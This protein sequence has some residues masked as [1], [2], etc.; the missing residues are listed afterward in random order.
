MNEGGLA[1]L[2]FGIKVKIIS[3]SMDQAVQ[4]MAEREEKDL[5]LTGYKNLK[6]KE[7]RKSGRIS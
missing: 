5:K 7:V 2:N 4:V 1:N 3:G 6:K